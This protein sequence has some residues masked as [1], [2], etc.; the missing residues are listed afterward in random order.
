MTE[1]APPVSLGQLGS[2]LAGHGFFSGLARFAG[3]LRAAVPA[4]LAATVVAALV[5]EFETV[6]AF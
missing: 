5:D 4:G 2:S 3:L 6:R 1:D